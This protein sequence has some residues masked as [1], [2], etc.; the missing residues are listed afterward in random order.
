MAADL[1]PTR[2]TDDGVSGTGIVGVL[3]MG[4][5]EDDVVGVLVVNDFDLR[6][7]GGNKLAWAADNFVVVA[8]VVPAGIVRADCAD[9]DERPV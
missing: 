3:R 5:W 8:V 9:D 1:D 7:G 6:G 4:A 2:L